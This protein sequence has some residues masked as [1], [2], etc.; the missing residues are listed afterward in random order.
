MRSIALISQKGGVGK[1]TIACG[2]AAYAAG[3]GLRTWVLDMDPLNASAYRWG[4]ERQKRHPEAPLVR[5][6]MAP[7]ALVFQR[8]LAAARADRAAL[9]LI[10]TPQATGDAHFSAVAGAH[11]VLA[12]CKPNFFDANAVLLTL[13][14]AQKEAKPVF[15][16]WTDVEP[17]DKAG[18]VA[19]AEEGLTEGARAIGLPAPAFCPV[20]LH[21]NIE[22]PHA[23]AQG[24]GA[25]ETAGNKVAGRDMKALARWALERA[26]EA[27]LA[28]QTAAA[29][30]APTSLRERMEA[31]KAARS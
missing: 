31:R 18:D 12:P 2:V 27:A 3:E 13:E 22:H 30:R 26:E 24:L 15:I 1:T 28:A 5:V 25:S 23:V 21:H 11:L 10:D 16:V 4:E 17:G 8:T 29:T 19:S 6:E 9:A 20:K 14:R 7:S